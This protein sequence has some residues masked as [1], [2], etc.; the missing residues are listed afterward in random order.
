MPYKSM[1]VI[2]SVLLRILWLLSWIYGFKEFY[3]HYD[4]SIY[5]YYFC[6]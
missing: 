5:Y 2:L 4:F 6:L 3:I 1:T